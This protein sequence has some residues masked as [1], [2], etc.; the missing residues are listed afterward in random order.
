MICCTSFG[1]EDRASPLNCAAWADA[2]TRE[3]AISPFATAP[4]TRCNPIVTRFTPKGTVI[5]AVLLLRSSILA[6]RTPVRNSAK[7]LRYLTARVRG[8]AGD[9][10]EPSAPAQTQPFDEPIP[11]S[12]Q[13]LL[14]E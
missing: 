6:C 7:G 8:A 14:R 10:P 1:I 11:H 12:A 4:Q 2:P 13:R 5:R 3:A 9:A